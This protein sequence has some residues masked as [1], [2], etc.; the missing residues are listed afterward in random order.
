VNLYV[1]AE[2]SPPTPRLVDGEGAGVPARP[3]EGDGAPVPD[4]GDGWVHPQDLKA[5]VNAQNL[6]GTPARIGASRPRSRCGRH[7][8]VP[9]PSGYTFYDPQ[10]AKEGYGDKLADGTTDANGDT[11]FDLGLGKYARATYRLHFLARC[12]RARGRPQRLGGGLE[13]RLRARVP[14]GFK[15][16][17]DLGH[18]ARGSKRTA[19][20]IAIDPR[21]ARIAA[22]DLKLERVERRFVSVLMKQPNGTY[23]YVSRPKE[24]PISERV[25]AFPATGPRAHAGERHAGATSSIARDTAAWS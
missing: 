6:F 17:G 11:E 1:V 3:H 9:R 20:L 13:P 2:A 10:R 7:S 21:A 16:D 15:P 23:K 22:K 8:R 4:V 19:H 5:R 25:V 14:G 12:V 24:V 18:V